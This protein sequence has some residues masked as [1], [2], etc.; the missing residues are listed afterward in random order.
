MRDGIGERWH[1]PSR[2]TWASRAG[3][4]GTAR[5]S[6]G[7]A[8]VLSSAT[9]AREASALKGRCAAA[10]VRGRAAAEVGAERARRIGAGSAA[11]PAGHRLQ[12]VHSWFGSVR[13]DNLCEQIDCPIRLKLRPR[14]A[15]QAGAMRSIGELIEAPCHPMMAAPLREIEPPRPWH[16]AARHRAAS[17]TAAQRP[18]HP[19]APHA[20]WEARRPTAMRICSCRR[21]GALLASPG[22]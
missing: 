14:S 10:V 7:L 9:L 21:S 13:R 5:S 3:K 16:S 2:A 11:A 15:C 8:A 19:Q 17:S 18:R 1:L 22:L 20:A 4:P 12:G 6:A